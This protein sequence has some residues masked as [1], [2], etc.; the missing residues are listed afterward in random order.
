[1]IIYKHVCDRCNVSVEQDAH[2]PAPKG[3]AY[4]EFSVIDEHRQVVAG[5][6]DVRKQYC[7]DCL[8]KV[9]IEHATAI[10]DKTRQLNDKL[11]FASIHVSAW[12]S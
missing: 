10:A 5:A 4:V 7:Q 2:N 8:L 6:S 11:R 9:L 3:W 12:S 1:M